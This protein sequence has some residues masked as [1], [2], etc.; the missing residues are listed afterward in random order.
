M[1]GQLKLRK[2]RKHYGISLKLLPFHEM[3]MSQIARNRPPIYVNDV[4][5][6]LSAGNITEHLNELLRTHYDNDQ[7]D[8]I[9]RCDCGH[10]HAMYEYLPDESN[11]CPI[12]DTPVIRAIDRPL[13]SQVWMRVPDGVITFIH[14]RFW[15][16][17]DEFFGVS[18]RSKL[19]WSLLEY[20]INPMYRPKEKMGANKR[21]EIQRITRALEEAGIRR[22]LEHF[23]RN[24][25]A[26]MDFV[27]DNATIFV[28]ASGVSNN[29]DR[30]AYAADWREFQTKYRDVIFTRELPF[31]SKTIMISESVGRVCL[32]DDNMANAMDAPKIIA[33]I[34][35]SPLKLSDQKVLSQCIKAQKTL[36]AYYSNYYQQTWAKKN[37]IMRSMAATRSPWTMRLTIAPIIG[38]HRYDE[39]HAPWMASIVA[40]SLH[41]A[42]VLHKRGYTPAEILSRIDEATVQYDE[43][44][45]EIMNMFI[46]ACPEGGIPISA[47]RNPT[48]ERLSNQPLYITKIKTDIYDNSLQLSSLVIKGSNADYDGDQ[49]Q[50]RIPLDNYE[51]DGYKRLSSHLGIMDADAANKIS[52]F[53]TLHPEGVTNLNLFRSYYR[54]KA[55]KKMERMINGSNSCTIV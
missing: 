14:P 17:F 9:P 43:E 53:M 45:H 22:G 31:P 38:P 10:L 1:S 7:L 23:Y 16:L 46:A 41:I 20:L 8:T 26:I 39:C 42:N 29:A 37:G 6:E 27:L 5:A 35:N 40:F 18:T 30:Y 11:I 34:V 54:N 51:K 25:D 28:R 48:L 52:G 50:I 12:C 33:S 24:F 32:I 44:I 4:A 21:N 3:L 36:V 55:I 13:E 47:L 19:V 2:R 15:A 49:F